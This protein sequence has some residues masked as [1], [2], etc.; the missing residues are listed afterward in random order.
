MTLRNE[1]IPNHKIMSSQQTILPTGAATVTIEIEIAATPEN[2]WKHLI[3]DSASWWRTDFL[4][5]KDSLGLHIEPKVGGLLFERTAETGCGFV[6]GQIIRFEPPFHLAHTAQIVP[7]W[8]GP[9]MSVVQITLE[10]T[11]S[12]TKLTLADSLVGHLTDETLSNM[13]EGWKMLYGEG[14]LKSFVEAQ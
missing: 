9:A 10:P 8:G 3:D 2:V 6:W 13:D 12:G 4:V 11:G 5:C 14:G 1:R 7:P